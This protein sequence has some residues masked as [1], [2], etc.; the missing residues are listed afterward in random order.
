M[1]LLNLVKFLTVLWIVIVDKVSRAFNFFYLLAVCLR[2]C[3]A[4]EELFHACFDLLFQY[5]QLFSLRLNLFLLIFEGL[6]TWW[7][8]CFL[9]FE[10]FD[11]IL[12]WLDL[13]LHIFEGLPIGRVDMLSIWRVY[14][15][16]RYS[17]RLIG[18]F[19]LSFWFLSIL[20]ASQFLCKR[21]SLTLFYFKHLSQL[22]NLL[23]SCIRRILCFLYLFLAFNFFFAE[24][25][26]R[27]V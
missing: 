27:H 23:S 3:S 2:C 5:F 12:L 22:C 15:L 26:L 6:P 13:S 4:F 24:L 18:T 10:L 8:Y 7:I 17:D 14:Y 21:Q 11:F 25:I 20:E 16:N 9:C 19:I 1:E